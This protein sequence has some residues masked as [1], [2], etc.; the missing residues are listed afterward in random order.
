MPQI[1]VEHSGHLDGVD[2]EEF[3]LELHPLV[4]RLAPGA[5]LEA[6]KTRVLR[7]AADVVGADRE[8]HAIANVSIALMAGRSE[9]TKGHLADAVVE[10]L[11]KHVE[12]MDGVR[13]HLSAEI[14]DLDPSYRKAEV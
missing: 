5:R 14:R 8:R 9:K 11:R 6:C 4:V 3:A 12:P 10:L 7:S 13:L 1:K 2:W